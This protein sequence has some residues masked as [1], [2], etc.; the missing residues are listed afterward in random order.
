V[1]DVVPG[2]QMDSYPGPL[3]QALGHL[4]EN[5]LVHAFTAPGD[6]EPTVTVA[7]SAEGSDVLVTVADNGVGIP[8]EHVRRVFDP[9]YTTRLG[10]GRSGLGLYITHNI[11]TGVLAGHIAVASTPG[12]DTTF[13]LRLPAAAPR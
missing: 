8:P 9:F 5:C 4:A 2:L 1:L 3:S 13:T 12:H 7:A 10:A 11:V 6:G